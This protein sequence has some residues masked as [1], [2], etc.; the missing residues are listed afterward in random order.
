MFWSMTSVTFEDSMRRV[1]APSFSTE[2]KRVVPPK[3]I[4]VLPRTMSPLALSMSVLL[5]TVFWMPP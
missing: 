4:S 3:L 2:L 5:P 1:P